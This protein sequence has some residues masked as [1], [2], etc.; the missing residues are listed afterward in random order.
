MKKQI[1]FVMLSCI[2][3]LSGTASAQSVSPALEH[4]LSQTLSTDAYAGILKSMVNPET[5]S[6]P[7]AVC[8]Q[9]HGGEDMARYQQSLAPMMRM[10]NP[11]NWV[12]PNAYLQMMT[13]MVDPETYTSWYN[14]WMKKYGGLVGV[15]ESSE[16]GAKE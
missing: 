3:M 16:D 2:A 6:D 7:V 8:G 4:S 13:P 9:C 10:I 11:V 1:L 15:G 12:S 14:A 5:L